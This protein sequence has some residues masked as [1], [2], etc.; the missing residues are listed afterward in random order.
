M[1][2]TGTERDFRSAQTEARFQGQRQT[3]AVFAATAAHEW[4]AGDFPDLSEEDALHSAKALEPGD[5]EAVWVATALR[6]IDG[7]G[8]ALSAD[9]PYGDPHFSEG[10]PEAATDP[11][12]RRRCGARGSAQARTCGEIA[13]LLSPTSAAVITVGFVTATWAEAVDEGW[14]DDPSPPVNG[15][16]AVLAVG[17][18]QASGSRPEALI[19]KNSWSRNWGSDG[20]GFMSDRY[21]ERH[22]RH[23]D[24]LEAVA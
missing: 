7:E 8:Q 4:M 23:T 15:A 17:L 2:A 13:A 6:G 18:L 3:C 21:L 11:A 14:I 12:R 9:W 1:N 20:Y 19:F 22:L 5:D 16:H 10:R 24:V